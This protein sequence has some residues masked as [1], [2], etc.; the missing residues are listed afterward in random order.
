MHLLSNFAIEVDKTL[1]IFEDLALKSK[2]TQ[3]AFMT[4]ESGTS[5]L[6]RTAAKA[7]HP[8]GSDEAGIASEFISFLK[9]RG[10]DLKIVTYRGNRFNIL[11]YDA[12]V[13]YYHWDDLLE[14]LN[15]WP[16][17]NR[18][19]L[20]VKEDMTNDVQKAGVRALGI[21]DKLI[22]GPFW[23]LIEKKG[24]ILH[25][26]PFLTQ[27]KTKLE[28]WGIDASPLL[29]G[30]PMFSEQDAE[31]HRDVIW[32]KL[33][34]SSGDVNFETLT[35]QVL[36]MCMHSLLLILERLCQ[37]QLPGGKYYTPNES[38]KKIA[39]NVPKTNKISEADF[40]ILD[41]LIRKKPNATI[42]ALDALIMW[43]QNKTL[44]WLD[45]IP[46]KEKS[47]LLESARKGAKVMAK[48]FK[49]RKE[50][51]IREKSD[52]LHKKL[53]EKANKEA[54]ENAKK[55]EATNVYID[56]GEKIQ[57]LSEG[58]K[59]KA[60]LCQLRFR[61]LVLKSTGQRSLFNK[62]KVV[63]DKRVALNSDELKANL[64]EVIRLN[65]G[66]TA[67]GDNEEASGRVR[68]RDERDIHFQTEKAKLYARLQEARRRR[69]I[70]NQKEKLPELLLD[71]KK[72]VGK[73]IKHRVVE[74]S[75]D[76]SFWCDGNVLEIRS[77]LVR[78]SS[79]EL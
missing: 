8:H 31:L 54:K 50:E 20:A 7:V 29:R 37:D 13:L 35:Q 76:D 2:N 49:E 77:W 59:V 38:L 72:L 36:E 21:I 15:D 30:E 16:N 70:L 4:K 41:L 9:G 60:L 52:L 32:E 26:T 45:S 53:Q 64:E 23:R 22:T 46:A 63:G 27:I 79:T 48:K 28:V 47:K 66:S 33:F 5:R 57:D 17:P 12:G 58:E 51:L 67:F 74:E 68:P 18:L 1:K 3:Y 11:F 78:E 56:I 34:T 61:Q 65:P 43:S 75:D 71:P 25:L 40:A 10:R 69:L 55:E 14:L 19:L 42:N 44:K 62:T 24:S 6:V 73:R 39:A